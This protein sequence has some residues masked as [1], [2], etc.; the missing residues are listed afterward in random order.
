[1]KNKTGDVVTLWLYSYN[2]ICFVRKKIKKVEG[3][4][5]EE[6]GTCIEQQK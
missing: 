1:M 5:L 6:T 4:E 3:V 2:D